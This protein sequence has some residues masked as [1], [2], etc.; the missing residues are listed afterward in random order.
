M[1]LKLNYFV[2]IILILIYIQF[3]FFRPYEDDESLYIL[4]GKAILQG[5]LNP[6]EAVYRGHY[7]NP[8][9]YII[10]SPLAPIIYGLGYIIGG[11][12]LSRFF[13]MIFIFLS[14]ILIYK[15][16]REIHGNPMISLIFAGFSSC[17]I[18]LAS[19]SLL[20]PVSLFFFI[21]SLFVVNKGMRVFGG[22]SAGLAVISKFFSLIPVFFILVYL[23]VKKRNGWKFLLGMIIVLIPFAILYNQ[24]TM[25]ILRF[26]IVKKIDVVSLESLKNVLVYLIYYLPLASTFC[27]LKFK[28]PTIKK[29]FIFFIPTISVLA[30][31]LITTNYISL[32]R[33]LPF[34]EFTAA[35]LAGRILIKTD[36]KILSL[37]LGIVVILNLYT[38]SVFVFYYPSYNS[39]EEK[40]GDVNGRILALNP[41]AF[42]LSK[43][44][45]IYATEDNVFS[46]HFFDYKL[47]PSTCD[48]ESNMEDYETALKDKFFDYAVISS[49]SPPEYS[50]YVQIE[51]LVRKY[52][53]PYFKQNKPNGIDIYKKCDR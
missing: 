35:I 13:A 31:H 41:H 27:L 52:Y 4:S 26:L 42:I 21:L 32:Y 12:F 22:I 53:C 28:N 3:I 8:F 1:N 11:V 2:L 25:I 33:Q 48:I 18:L 51:N 44:W 24:L 30:F 29:H 20:D 6:F 16:T 23:L 5:K 43:G 49:Y 17:T 40:L 9:Q 34:A 38:S 7:A 47:D 37:I 19:D 15:L 36:K 39:V 50:R 46:Y 45:D 10:G 14:L